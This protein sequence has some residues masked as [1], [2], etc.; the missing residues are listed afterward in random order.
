M[1]YTGEEEFWGPVLNALEWSEVF[2]GGLQWL[3]VV[4]KVLW[5]VCKLSLGLSCQSRNIS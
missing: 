4:F 2:V 3:K 1:V 5:V